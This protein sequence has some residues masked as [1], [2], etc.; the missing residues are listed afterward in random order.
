V[1]GF[2]RRVGVFP[3]VQF[4]TQIEGVVIVDLPPPSSIQGV[5]TGV[6]ALVGEFADMTYAT[7]VDTSGNVTTFSQPIRAFS[8]QDLLNK[9]GGW[10]STIGEFGGDMG[11]GFAE[12]RNKSFAELVIVPV[13]LASSKGVRMW[14]QLPTSIS[15]TDPTPIT[16]VIAATVSAGLE[17]KTG[18][19]RVKNG[20]AFT[21]SDNVAYDGGTDGALTATNPAATATFT[22]VTG[23]FQTLGTKIG[24][25][26]V[27]GVLQPAL[28]SV[29][30]S[31]TVSVAFTAPGILNVA[32]N[33]GFPSAGLLFIGGVNLEVVA[34]TGLGVNT[35]T[36]VTG[37]VLGTT[38]AIHAISSP[39]SLLVT[40]SGTVLTASMTNVDVTATVSSTSGYPNSG[41]VLIDAELIAYSGK[42]STTFTGLTRAQ[43]GT[44]AAAHV[45]A[46][47]V[48]LMSNA[49]TYRVNAVVSETQLTLARQ[50]TVDPSIWVNEAAQ[51]WRIYI[52]S[53]ADTGEN[54]IL[55]DDGG[56][57]IPARPLDASISAS[58]NILPTVTIP[59]NTAISWNPLSGLT[60]RTVSNVAGLIYTAAVQAPNAVSSSA[61]DA[62]YSTAFD[63]LLTDESPGSDVSIIWAARKSDLIRAKVRSHCN[64]ASSR[65]LGRIGMIS[66]SLD[67]LNINTA[68][69]N[70]TPGVG[71]TRDERVVYDWPG[72]LTFVPEA[73]GT[74]IA[75]ADGKTTTDGILDTTSDGWM[76]SICSNLA[77]ERNPG[78]AGAPVSTVMSN[79]LGLQRG[80]P[81]LTISEYI[82]F[83]Q[84]GIAAPRQTKTLGLLYQS[85]ITSSVVSGQT[86]IN[87]RRMADFIEDSLAQAYNNYVKQPLTQDLKDTIETET[88]AFLNTLLSPT[89]PAAQRIEAFSVDVVSGNTPETEAQGIFVVIVRVRLLA[90]ADYIVL[91]A[92]VGQTVV[93]STT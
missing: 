28:A 53:N 19:N 31:T 49:G 82:A 45:A 16:P 67:M 84:F 39:V 41:T 9:F 34:Y 22:S 2:L 57:V 20:K 62:L 23:N 11:N 64:D 77:P 81:N 3:S 43:N 51:P 58:T 68:L 90:T 6:T 60:M 75:T 37:A 24:D 89:N 52:S 17:F 65:G 55:S 63:S 42:T 76:A 40:N 73:S 5:G 29:P 32:S 71:A 21:F 61:L 80:A 18:A 91:Q 87:R 56:F 66:P 79:V 8:S 7:Q 25:A 33:A 1:A 72:L 10:D 50:D 54:K 86:N 78:Q 35:F 48:A 85:G 26:V 92:S 12:L 38:T 93:I 83:K 30:A 15:Y 14:R 88:V 47:T 69:G 46:K 44:V 4:I 70:A 27:V 59:S 13:N 74:V 36:G